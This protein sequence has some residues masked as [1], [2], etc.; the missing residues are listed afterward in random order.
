MLLARVPGI[1]AGRLPHDVQMVDLA[2]T[3]ASLRG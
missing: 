1:A 3:I 2:P